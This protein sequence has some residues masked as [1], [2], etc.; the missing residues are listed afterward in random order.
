MSFAVL[1][2]DLT[3]LACIPHN[4]TNTYRRRTIEPSV[5]RLHTH[6]YIISFCSF[7]FLSPFRV[8]YTWMIIR[9]V[10]FF[11]FSL[12]FPKKKNTEKLATTKPY[13]LRFAI[14]LLNLYF[15]KENCLKV[16]M[17]MH[18]TF[19]Y[20]FFIS[21]IPLLLFL[22]TI[23]VGF[24]LGFGWYIPMTSDQRQLKLHHT[25]T[26]HTYTHAPPENC[27]AKSEKMNG[28]F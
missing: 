9:V 6:T 19:P 18:Y 2:F 14:L 28:S 16:N 1:Y 26:T 21:S 12:P 7:C 10:V 3:W 23:A 22:K 15:Q 11:L 27:Y 17:F 24:F 5:N 20:P 4:I 25:T 8:L 13:V